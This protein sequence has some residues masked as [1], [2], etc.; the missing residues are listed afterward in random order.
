[1]TNTE[2]L[3]HTNLFV[4]EIARWIAVLPVAAGA[5]VGIQVVVWL[6]SEM[7]PGFAGTDLW[8]QLVN[9]VAGPYCLVL[10]GA[11]TAPRYRFM[12]AMILTLLHA[13][14]SITVTGWA[15]LH[16]ERT[17]YSLVWVIIA[18]I[19]GICATVGA[20]VQIRSDK[21]APR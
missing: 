17:S 4:I 9:S 1:M 14:G 11:K 15:V 7:S 5:Y 3:T 16:P 2:P 19:L 21:K 13:I 18:C 6:L 8:S 10:A 12:A 20:C